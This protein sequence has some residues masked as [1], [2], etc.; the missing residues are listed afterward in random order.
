MANNA[1]MIDPNLLI[2]AGMNPK[3]GL[4]IKFD[5]YGEGTWVKDSIKRVLRIVD[6]QD[7]INRYVWYNLP[8]GL[9]GQLMERIL[10]YRGQAMLFYIP[11]NDT[12]Y[13]LP[14]AL[15]GTIDVYGRF[16]GVTPLPFNG[17]V[18]DNK[19]WI[20]GLV[21]KPFYDIVTEDDADYDKT[22]EIG[23]VLLKDY[24]EQLSQTIISRQILNDP[25]LDT[26]AEAYPFARTNMIANSGIK[27]YKVLGPEQ[28]IEVE[29]T[30]RTIKEHALSGDP[31]VA[32][33]NNIESQELTVPAGMIKTEEY[34]MY[35]QS[36]DNFRLSLYGLDQ[37][38]LFEKK[39]HTLESEQE[40]NG[41][42]VGLV[43]QDGLTIRQRFCV[44]ANSLFGTSIWCDASSTLIGMKDDQMGDTNE[45]Q[46]EDGGEDNE[47]IE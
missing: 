10:Y 14:Y 18:K 2:Q 34:L 33:R 9:N 6:E 23:C 40:M 3:T 38:G 21:R 42:N 32:I 5:Q 36:L 46:E 29:A 39:A 41:S 47:S 44:I 17:A 12:F 37:G 22:L 24:S 28:A 16:T 26:M 4:P 31:Y 1:K 11:A 13:F 30:S 25:I 43:Y 27:G 8:K 35:M 7:A 15:D 45:E 19:A 20:K